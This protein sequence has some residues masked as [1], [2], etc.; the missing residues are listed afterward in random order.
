M[1]LLIPLLP[2]LGF[3]VNATIGRRWPKSLSGGLATLAMALSFGAFTAAHA[4]P[5]TIVAIGADNVNGKGKGKSYPGGVG[6]SD[7]FPAQLETLL[8]AQQ[9]DARV[10]S[11]N[12][13]GMVTVDA[14]LKAMAT[15]KG[16]PLVG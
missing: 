8:R 7:A 2:F 5:A 16:P 15:E 10:V 6:R 1:L 4:E 12:T 11:A 3:L 9:I 14:G 13:P